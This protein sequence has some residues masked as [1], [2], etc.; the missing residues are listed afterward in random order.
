M[1][2][3]LCPCSLRLGACLIPILTSTLV[4]SLHAQPNGIQINTVEIDHP[5]EQDITMQL[6]AWD[7]GGQVIYH[8]THQ[9]FLTNRSLFI[10]VWNA[11]HGYEQGKL[12][13]WLDAIKSRAP[14]SP[15][16]IVATHTDERDADIHPFQAVDNL[17]YRLGP[18]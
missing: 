14:E 10:V 18:P 15:V 13:Y 6:K 8:A 17:V 7:F 5:S 16:L 9:F 12:Y 2:T 11:R 1:R 4:S 3:T